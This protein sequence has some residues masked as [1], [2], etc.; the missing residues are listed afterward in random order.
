MVADID[1]GLVVERLLGAGQTNLLGGDFNANVLLGY[2]VE[3]GKIAGRVKNSMITGNVYQV[4][5]NLAAIGSEARWRGG[6]LRTPALYCKEVSVA[7]S[8]G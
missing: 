8:G 1:E 3:H 6:S 5:S 7:R 4:L 2:K